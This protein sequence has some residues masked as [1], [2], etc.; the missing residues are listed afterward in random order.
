MKDRYGR[1]FRKSEILN[2]DLIS[3]TEGRSLDDFTAE[4]LRKETVLITDPDGRKRLYQF[5]EL[6]DILKANHYCRLNDPLTRQDILSQVPEFQPA[7]QLEQNAAHYNAYILNKYPEFIP[8][9]KIYVKE[10]L[11]LQDEFAFR[12]TNKDDIF[13]NKSEEL[14]KFYQALAD[15]PQEKQ[16]AFNSLFIT[17]R[18]LYRAA[19]LRGELWTFPA[20]WVPNEHDPLEQ[21]AYQRAI[22]ARQYS[23]YT[24]RNVL[25]GDAFAN[26]EAACLHSWGMDAL[27]LLLE[28][29]IGTNKPFQL[30]DRSMYEDLYKMEQN[31]R[32]RIE[33]QLIPGSLDPHKGQEAF[34]LAQA[35]SIHSV[36]PKPVDVIAP[37]H[38]D[39]LE[40]TATLAKLNNSCTQYMNYIL[41]KLN[42]EKKRHF[43]L[44][45]ELPSQDEPLTQKYQA[46][47]EL[48]SSLHQQ[49]P[50]IDDDDRLDEF[51]KLYNQ[52][53]RQ[54]TIAS[55]RDTLGIRFL[56]IVV[57]ILSLGIKNLFTLYFT[58]GY[59]GFWNSRGDCFN[60]NVTDI[61]ASPPQLS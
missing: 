20:K 30:F 3:F 5:P 46:V 45:S 26:P 42:I 38:E 50:F 41:A 32:Q 31:L 39:T 34:K 49:D 13:A 36:A 48:Y 25:T 40:S 21:N 33:G 11:N 60:E 10:I 29:H 43:P 58:E 27:Y 8:L 6:Q 61:L 56:N 23:P 57:S 2:A 59:Y 16:E 1:K 37:N 54:E 52:K 55:H 4:E 35:G 51:T 47:Y 14:D 9:L 24:H 18:T 22:E 12:D 7:I 28:Y 17:N 44:P 15:M 19:T 53:D